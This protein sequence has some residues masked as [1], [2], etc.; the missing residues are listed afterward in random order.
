[1]P[2][3]KTP[4]FQTSDG[5]TYASLAIAQR[6]EMLKLC[7]TASLTDEQTNPVLQVIFDHLDEVKAILS[8][9]GRKPRKMNG[10]KKRR[11]VLKP[12]KHG[13]VDLEKAQV[14]K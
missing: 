10:A 8:C 2:I 5:N 9:T 14:S 11:T 6:A 13:V 7:T 1:M 4:A 3:T 12:D